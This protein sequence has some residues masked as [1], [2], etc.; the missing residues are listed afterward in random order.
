MPPPPVPAGTRTLV[1]L[2]EGL[3]GFG[4]EWDAPLVELRKAPGVFVEIF[5]WSPVSGLARIARDLALRL[6]EQLAKLP[7]SVTRVLLFGHSAGGM[8]TAF[9][10]KDIRTNVDVHIVNIGAP[11][12]GM[13]TIPFEAKDFVWAP[14]FFTM[15]CTFTRYPLPAA[16]VSIESWVTTW[17][18]DPVMQP[19]FGHDP[20][21][22]HVGPPGPRHVL[23]PGGDH[24][25][26]LDEV[27]KE[28]LTSMGLRPSVDEPR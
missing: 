5:H 2:V 27:M 19:R 10:A 6:D 11:Y 21:D 7:P 1:V 4:W 28:T 3:L 25:R 12:A 22:P 18:G 15:G 14:I 16:R 26:V 8:V 20:G 17:P 23:P 13:Q 24:N 9:A